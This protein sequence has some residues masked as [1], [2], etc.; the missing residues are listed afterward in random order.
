M[1]IAVA[2]RREGLGQA[3]AAGEIGVLSGGVSCFADKLRIMKTLSDMALLESGED[4]SLSMQAD[5]PDLDFEE[6]KDEACRVH[7]FVV[8]Q[9]FQGQRLDQCVAA[10][11]P[12]HSRNR[13]QSW[14][15]DGLLTVEGAVITE[16]KRKIFAGQRLTLSEEPDESI[17]SLL[18]EDIPIDVVFED[19]HI[20]VVNKP[21]GLV[22][23]PG[24]GNWTGTLLNALLFHVPGSERVPRAGIVHR[25]DK[26]TTGLMVVAKTLEAQTDLVRQ[27][28]ARTVKRQYWALAQGVINQRGTVDAPIGR[29]PNQRIK[30]AVTPGGKPA[31]THYRVK[32]HFSNWTL[33]ECTLETGRTHQIRV[34]MAHIGHPLVGDPVY[35]RPAKD[36]VSFGRQA[37]HAFKLGLI[38]PHTQEQ[39]LW[40]VDLPEDF[41][42]LLD[43]VSEP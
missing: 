20:L 6:L 28:Q 13:L 27:L 16:P 2:Q 23:H 36:F 25:L 11:L 31:I 10:L 3:V 19:E 24:S 17:T 40:S 12:Q 5:S 18:P 41:E 22:V 30:M 38:H 39:M 37:L 4:Y 7:H 34:H 35:G 8:S 43:E 32:A 14:I 9:A 26:E 42:A 29:H 21:A 1:P 15:R 33:L